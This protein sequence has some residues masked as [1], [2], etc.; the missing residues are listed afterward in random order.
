[1]RKADVRQASAGAI[2]TVFAPAG[3]SIV[4]EF[5]ASENTSYHDPSIVM[6]AMIVPIQAGLT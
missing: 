3:M 2:S 4:K 6:A 5:T 1:M